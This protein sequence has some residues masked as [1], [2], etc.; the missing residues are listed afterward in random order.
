MGVFRHTADRWHSKLSVTVRHFLLS[1]KRG[2]SPQ[3]NRRNKQQVHEKMRGL[4]V[5]R[6]IMTEC[7][8]NGT[9]SVAMKMY[10]PQVAKG[11]QESN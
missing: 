8:E 11:Q 7:L 6:M 9:L 5:T 2:C 1:K 10:K 3:D 4:V